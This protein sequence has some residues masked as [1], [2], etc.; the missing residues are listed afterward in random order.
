MDTNRYQAMDSIL[1]YASEH[2]LEEA[3]KL[4]GAPLSKTDVQLLRT[5]TLDEI[6]SLNSLNKKLGSIIGKQGQAEDNN[7]N[8]NNNN[9]SPPFGSAPDE[10]E[11]E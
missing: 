8:N 9:S 2:T 6:K 3:L 11:E 7:N 10:K 4:F 5:L 1:S